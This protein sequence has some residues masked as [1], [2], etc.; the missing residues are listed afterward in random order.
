MDARTDILI[1][2]GGLAGLTAARRLLDA[3]LSVRVLDKGRSPGGRMATRRLG[4]PA[5][6][7]RADHGAQFFTVREPAFRQV[8]DRWLAED[9][10]FEWARGWSDGSLALQVIDGHP[11]YAARGGFNAL[12][13]HL[14]GGLDVRVSTDVRLVERRQDGWTATTVAGERFGGRGLLLTSPVPQSLALLHAGSAAL[15]AAD[16]AALDRISYGPCL[17]GLFVLDGEVALPEPG[18][19]QRPSHPISWIADNRRK[20]ISP[21]AAAIT[22]QASPEESS[23]RWN[24]AEARTLTWMLDTLALWLGLGVAVRERQLKRWRYAVPTALHPDRCLSAVSDMPLIFAGDAFGGPRIE[25][26]YLSGL[27]AAEAALAVV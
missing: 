10:V 19:I 9:R 25:G 2:G 27:A 14:A 12:A 21:G 3:G 13:K 20:G 26:A 17:C 7:I 1:I 11:R 15:S 5:P 8:V 4:A 23:R 18:G 16:R 22:M 24:D 6:D